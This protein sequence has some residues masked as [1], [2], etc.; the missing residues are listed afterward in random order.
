M[1]ANPKNL[2]LLFTIVTIGIFI[3]YWLFLRMQMGAN[4]SGERLQQ[5]GRLEYFKKG[6]AYNLE[7]TPQLAEGENFLKQI[8]DSNV[9][10]HLFRN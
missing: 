3:F 7:R 2:V 6:M 1:F 4:P 9:V 5:M 10:C 8:I